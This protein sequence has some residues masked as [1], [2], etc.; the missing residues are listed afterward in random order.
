M[1]LDITRFWLD[2]RHILYIEEI[3]FYAFLQTYYCGK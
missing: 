1:H 2:E 3:D